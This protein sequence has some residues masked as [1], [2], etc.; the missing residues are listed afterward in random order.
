[1]VTVEKNRVQTIHQRM[2]P[3]LAFELD[4]FIVCC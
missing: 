2:R 1:L 3:G 4:G